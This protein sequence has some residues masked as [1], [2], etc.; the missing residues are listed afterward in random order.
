VKPTEVVITQC[1]VTVEPAKK[2]PEATATLIVRVTESAID[3]GTPGTVLTGVRVLL[4][5]KKRHLSRAGCRR[6]ADQAGAGQP[7]RP[8]VSQE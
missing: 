1:D 7:E 6:R 3:K 4:H 2:P 5:K 8:T